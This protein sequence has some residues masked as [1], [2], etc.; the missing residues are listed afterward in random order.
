MSR[1][2]ILS[3]LLRLAAGA[4]LLALVACASSAPS[5]TVGATVAVRT[6]C[7]GTVVCPLTGEIVCVDRCPVARDAKGAQAAKE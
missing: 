7:P 6:D 5:A 2:S 4:A 3:N 1:S